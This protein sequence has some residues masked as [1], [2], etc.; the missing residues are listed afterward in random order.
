MGD[1]QYKVSAY[2]NDLLFSLTNPSISLLNLLREFDIYGNISN[3]KIIYNK[4]EAMGVGTPQT[5][6][7]TLSYNF[8]FKWTRTALKY[9]D[10]SVPA[11][12]KHTYNMHFPPLLIK[13]RTFLGILAQKASIPGSAGATSSKCVS[14]P[15]SSTYCRHSQSLSQLHSLNK[16]TVN[17]INLYEL[18]GNRGYHVPYS[19]YQRSMEV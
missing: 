14:C 6:M 17:F 16:Y 10:A 2:A 8:N 18:I 15:N 3:L 9:L 5:A 12:L 19:P 1:T 13:T 7:Q 4:S 11:N